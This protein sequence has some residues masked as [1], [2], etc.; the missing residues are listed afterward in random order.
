MKIDCRE[1]V[2]A[3]SGE[4]MGSTSLRPVAAYKVETAGPVVCPPLRVL[5]VVPYAAGSAS[6]PFVE[7]QNAPM[8]AAGVVLQTFSLASRTAPLTV[9]K[10]W[11][12]LRRV[13]SCFRPE[14]VHAQFGT[15]TALVAVLST[16]LPV[17]VTYRGSDLNGWCSRASWR[18]PLARLLSQIAA[19]RARQII[20]VSDE[21]KSRLWWRGTIATVIPTGVDTE[22]FFP[23]PG[24]DVRREL[25]WGRDERVVIFNASRDPMTKRLALAQAS[26]EVA[27]KICG[28][29]RFV[30]LDGNVPPALVPNMMN[31][32]DCLLL[33]SDR[34]GSPTVVQEAMAC[35]LPVVSVDVGDVKERLRGVEPTRIVSRNPQ[36]LGRAVAEVISRRERSNGR[37]SAEQVSAG[38]V[39]RQLISVYQ[40]A[41]SFRQ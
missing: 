10:E 37:Q 21:V 41:S 22:A 8:A 19:L 6:M 29:I 14:V 27:E 1:P 32:S 31:A 15:V 39:A 11:R 17:V 16:S 18:S 20:C 5:S 23:Q 38:R 25:G 7:R 28:K 9:M 13:I 3:V 40:R 35:C 2:A 12:R 34:E 30:I 4:E 26:I 33:T 36:D 24:D